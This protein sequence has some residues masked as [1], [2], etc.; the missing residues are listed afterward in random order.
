MF[1]F[2]PNLRSFGQ[3]NEKYKIKKIVIDA[4]HGGKDPGAL[5]KKFHEKHI[6]LAIALKLG[7]Y[8]EVNMKDVEVIYTRDDDTFVELHKRAEIANT[9]KADLFISIHVNSTKSKQPRGTSTYVMGLHKSE[10]NLEVALRENSVIL[11]ESD[12]KTKYQGYDPNSPE[13]YIVLSLMQDAYIEQSILLASKVQEQLKKRAGRKDIGV[14]QA[15][16]I[17]LYNCTMPSILVETGF[18]SNKEEEKY[19]ISDE[20]QSFIASAIYR[21]F[22]EYKKEIENISTIDDKTQEKKQIKQKQ[23]KTSDSIDV[24]TSEIVFKVQIKSSVSQIPLDSRVFKGIKNIEEVLENKKYRYFV[25]STD[26]PTE[27][28]NLQNEVRKKIPDAF[29]SAFK[30]GKRIDYKEGVEEVKKKK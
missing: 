14:K 21:A 4:G 7:K 16:L 17:V 19:L 6:T 2:F 25:G 18:I 23:T 27:I 1:C 15:G 3:E 11:D 20:G 10:E 24:K 8:I 9:N 12:Y 13:T 22:K 28:I 30:N 5:G 29:V 26:N